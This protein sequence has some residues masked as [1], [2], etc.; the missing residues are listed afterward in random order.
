MGNVPDKIILLTSRFPKLSETFI[1]REALELSDRGLLGAIFS[2]APALFAENVPEADSLSGI[3]RHP[4]WSCFA[5]A[6]AGFFSG[7]MHGAKNAYA[8]ACGTAVARLVK[9]SD[10]DLIHA[11]W[12]TW[13]LVCAIEAGRICNVPI[14]VTVHAHDLYST[15]IEILADRFGKVRYIIVDSEYNL[16]WIKKKFLASIYDKTALVHNGLDLAR[17]PFDPERNTDPP[18][19]LAVGRVV[20][21][22][23]FDTLI[24][25]LGSLSKKGVS[26]FAKIVGDG[27][28][29]NSLLEMIRREN[30]SDRFE[31][32]GALPF[33]KVQEL[34]NRACV[35]VVPSK[36]PP[37]STHDGLPTVI[38]EAMALGTPV[39]A[40]DVASIGEVIKND[41]TGLLIEQDN[42][43][44]LAEAI[45][46]L[47]D[48]EMLR[49]GIATK[50]RAL[51]KEQFD[52]EKCYD[53]L[54]EAM[55]KS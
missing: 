20:D 26:F 53:K 5:N 28:K 21:F 1:L 45:E 36:T 37:G 30:L 18:L 51:A 33:E 54:I 14:G 50:A 46:K 6:G 34:M 3:V 23:G 22:K 40:T 4:P 10:A 47:L 31:L 55:S 8:L 12:A 16:Q 15:P 42:P 48:N 29:K 35:M 2:M 44:L 52:A 9:Q 25:A 41:S 17:F 11:H 43:Q 24:Q 38:S 27:P 39:V 7:G 13:P 32:T 49:V 19:V